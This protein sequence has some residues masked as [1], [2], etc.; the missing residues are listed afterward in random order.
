MNYPM[1][2]YKFFTYK[3]DKGSNC[4]TA[5]STYAGKIVKGL[6]K[7]HPGDTFQEEYGKRLAA[8]RCNAKIAAKRV[9][10]AE[11]KVAEAKAQMEAA[12]KF[13]E[14]MEHYLNDAQLELDEANINIESLKSQF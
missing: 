5:V 1:D 3:N 12:H 6:A 13:Y 2:R 11:R 4:V 8:A 10:R 9:Q 7:C 14:A